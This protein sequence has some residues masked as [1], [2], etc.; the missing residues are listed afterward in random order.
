[1]PRI[2][3]LP[4]NEGLEDDVGGGDV[5]DHAIS[6]EAGP[7]VKEVDARR[8]HDALVEVGAAAVV[9]YVVEADVERGDPE[10][11]GVGQVGL[12]DPD[13]GLGGGHEQWAGVGEPQSGGEVD[14]IPQI[15]RG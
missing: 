15:A 8:G 1:V 11:L 4:G 6:G 12:G 5:S 9:A 13:A 2:Q 14:W 10:D 3:H 7:A